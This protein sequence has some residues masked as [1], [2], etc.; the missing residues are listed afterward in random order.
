ME[1]G[2][3]DLIDGPTAPARTRALFAAALRPRVSGRRYGA[4]AGFDFSSSGRSAIHVLDET[5]GSALLSD[6]LQV[7][8]RKKWP[9]EVCASKQTGE[10]PV[11]GRSKP[12]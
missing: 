1:P 6:G 11:L 3:C 9:Q 2:I 5:Q 7:R 12:F 10:R 8:E 4:P